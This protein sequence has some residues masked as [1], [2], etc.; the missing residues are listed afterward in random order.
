METTTVAERIEAGNETTERTGEPSVE[1]EDVEASPGTTEAD[2]GRPRQ[3]SGRNLWWLELLNRYGR[4]EE[5]FIQ[6]SAR[7]LTYLL[8]QDELDAAIVVAEA[9]GMDRATRVLLAIGAEHPFAEAIF[10]AVQAGDAS[11]V[12]RLLD[13]ASS[14]GSNPDWEARGIDIRRVIM[15]AIGAGHEEVVRLLMERRLGDK[16]S[17]LVEAAS[18]GHLGVVRLLV[19]MGADPRHDHERALRE[20]VAHGHGEVA[21]YLAGLGG[22]VWA[23]ISDADRPARLF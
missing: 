10:E 19:D 4:D 6:N 5:E 11:E 13:L 9:K 12:R 2:T 17:A 15:L 7:M 21:R 8:E 22:D 18:H 16:N 20:A 23:A 3:E 1:R 14:Q